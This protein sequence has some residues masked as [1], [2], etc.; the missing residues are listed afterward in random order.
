[1]ASFDYVIIDQKGKEKKGSMEGDNVQK[2]TSALKAEGWIPISVKEQTLLTKDINLEIGNGI[3][4][5]DLSV[6]CRQIT[7]ILGAGVTVISALQMLSEQTEKKQMQ[8]AIK[9][10][11]SSVERG[12][13][14][15]SSMVMPKEVFPPILVN[16]VEA[17]E[18]SGSLETAFERMAVHF[19]KEA[20]LK[21]MIKQAMVYPLVICVV[22]IA[23]IC[24]MMTV[25]VPNFIGMFEDMDTELPAIT[26]LVVNISNFMVQ[27]WWL[28]LGIAILIIVGFTAF[29]KSAFGSEFLGRV[30]LKLPLF[31]G[32]IIKSSSARL[33]RTLSTLITAGIPLLEA[34]QITAR[35]MDNIIVKNCLQN[36][37]EEVARGVPLSKPLQYS[38][39]FPP[40]VYQMIGIGEETGNMEGMMDK[41]A[42]YYDEEVEAATKA[43]TS[44]L[45]PLVIV[46]LAL[47]VGVIIMA[48]MSPMFSLYSNIENA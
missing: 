3:K 16:M 18:A 29:K 1:M 20:K 41:V 45:E 39:I 38:G 30:A 14:L 42:D 33:T 27:K 34:L 8:H 35:T 10:V 37:S 6:F 46:I 44:V 47:I 15:A 31:G 40:L 19:E 9:E 4:P 17:G 13:T 36:A 28:L 24:V 12:E 32:L 43:L 11:Q 5:R 48:I 7:S 26:Q 25:V 21:S 22:A 23:A 2:V